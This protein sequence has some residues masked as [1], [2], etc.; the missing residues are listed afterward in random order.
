ML[1][2]RQ[3]RVGT[4]LLEQTDEWGVQ[5]ARYMTLET[6]ELLSHD[7]IAGLPAAS[8][9]LTWPKT[10]NAVIATILLHHAKVRI[11]CGVAS[12][13]ASLSRSIPH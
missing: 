10:A 9:Y 11:W 1:G 8:A 5:R 3:R 4:I 7:P 12:R 6:I 2:H 13:D